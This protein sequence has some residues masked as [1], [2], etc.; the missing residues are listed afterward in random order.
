MKLIALVF[1]LLAAFLI[2]GCSTPRFHG[3]DCRDLL[4]RYLAPGC[5]MSGAEKVKDL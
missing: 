2:E 5:T 1:V 4:G 3:S